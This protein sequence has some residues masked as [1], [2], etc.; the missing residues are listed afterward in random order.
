MLRLKIHPLSAGHLPN[1]LFAIFLSWSDILIYWPI[2]VILIRVKFIEYDLFVLFQDLRFSHILQSFVLAFTSETFFVLV[3]V[4]IWHIFCS[5]RLKMATT[6]SSCAS[7]TQLAIT[8]SGRWTNYNI[9]KKAP[10]S[11]SQD[12]WQEKSTTSL[13]NTNQY[14]P[15][16]PQICEDNR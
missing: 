11:L 2:A 12:W 7:A 10:L 14:V 13:R 1:N 15:Q 8:A 3:L 5:R 16:P 9:P 4:H 6:P